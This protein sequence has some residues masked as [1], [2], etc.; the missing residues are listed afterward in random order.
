MGVVLSTV[1]SERKFNRMLLKNTRLNLLVDEWE[2]I[3]VPHPP[4]S[5]PRDENQVRCVWWHTGVA[6]SHPPTCSLPAFNTH[7]FQP[8]KRPTFPQF[9]LA[10]PPI[11]FSP[12][13]LCCRVS[14]LHGLDLMP[15][16]RRQDVRLGPWVLSLVKQNSA[17]KRALRRSNG[18]VEGSD[19]HF[20]SAL[21]A[22]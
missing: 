15:P 3:T 5:H 8:L 20:S 1:F 7:P 2:V 17:K 18:A 22:P 11:P 12:P 13:S 16:G 19:Q 14:A 9:S 21:P 6:H 4:R 10:A